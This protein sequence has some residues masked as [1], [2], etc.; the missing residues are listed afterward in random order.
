MEI[1]IE[2]LHINDVVLMIKKLVSVKTKANHSIYNICSNKP[3]K[4]TK[5]ISIIDKYTKK[6][7]KLVIQI[8]S[9][10]IF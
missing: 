10:L 8:Y 4:I 3:V 7:L 2:I 5:V 9:L 1:I 6:K